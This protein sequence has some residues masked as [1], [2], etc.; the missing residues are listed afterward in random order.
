ML[1]FYT[2]D[3]NLLALAACLICVVGQGIAL[4]KKRY[5][6]PLWIQTIKYIATCCLTLTLLVVL[7]V[8]IPM[9]GMQSFTMM[10]FHGSMLYHHF[11]CPV[12]AILSFLLLERTPKMQKKHTFYA[13]IPTGIYAVVTII[14]NILKVEE[15]PYSFLRVYEQPVYISIIWCVVILGGAYFFAWGIR[16]LQQF[17]K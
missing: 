15:G 11:L 4:K 10:M 3:S 17:E 9:S 5:E 1:R 14:L 12:L 7:F 8:L 6:M 13:M 16:K 2:Q